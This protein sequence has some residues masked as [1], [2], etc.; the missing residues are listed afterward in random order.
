MRRARRPRGGLSQISAGHMPRDWVGG[1]GSAFSRKKCKRQHIKSVRNEVHQAAQGYF[2]AA[3]WSQ[4]GH[5]ICRHLYRTGRPH[6]WGFRQKV[7]I[8]A[9]TSRRRPN[10]STPGRALGEMERRKSESPG[11]TF[12]PL[13]PLL[14]PPLATFGRPD[15][16]AFFTFLVP[17][18]G[19]PRVGHFG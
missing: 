1:F 18:R 14:G 2:C 12:R 6:I 15:L 9:E 19:P 5:V 17:D 13:A 11:A 16:G 3:R 4:R 10:F 8:L 7:A